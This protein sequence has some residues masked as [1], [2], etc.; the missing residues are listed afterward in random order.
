[1]TLFWYWFLNLTWGLPMTLAGALASLALLLTGRK[2]RWTKYGPVFPVTRGTGVSLGFVVIC[3]KG[4]KLLP[5]ERGHSLQNALFGPFMIFLVAI[6]SAVRFRFRRLQK[7]RP[8]K[9]YDAVWFEGDATRRG[10]R[11]FEKDRAK[12]VSE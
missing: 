10:R 7:K 9:P 1:M 8:L 4:E 11:L 5:H 2:G 6:P 12:N 3:D